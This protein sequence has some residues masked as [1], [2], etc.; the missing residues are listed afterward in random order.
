[1]KKGLVR[2]IEKESPDILALQESKSSESIQHIE[3]QKLRYV[4]YINPAVKK[5]YSGTMVLTKEKPLSVLNG[6]GMKEFDNEGR[7]QTLEFKDFYF[8]NT[9]FPNSQRDLKRLDYKLDFDTAFMRYADKLKMQK[10]LIV[11][12][13]MNVAHADIDIARPKENSN[14]AGFTKAERD[15]MTSFLSH[16]FID[17]YRYF[18]RNDVKYSWWSYRFNARKKNIGWR[19]DY[20]IVTADII[21]RVLDS[22]IMS[23]VDGSDHAPIALNLRL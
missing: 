23:D 22:D 17:A 18:H 13:D 20:F 14:N 19:I 5:G 12:G 16:G 7:V 9:Y 8:I 2:F 15:W 4:Q 10:P 1:M 6:I 3:L 11:C 21:N